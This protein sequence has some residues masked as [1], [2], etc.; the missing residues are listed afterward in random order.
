[1]HNSLFFSV[2]KRKAISPLA[3]PPPAKE[4]KSHLESDAPFFTPSLW[5]KYR[6]PTPHDHAVLSV[7]EDVTEELAE[8]QAKDIP[9][10]TSQA[11]TTVTMPHDETGRTNDVLILSILEKMED[12]KD[13]ARCERDY[14]LETGNQYYA[15]AR[16]VQTYLINNVT[17]L[18][19]FKSRIFAHR[20]KTWGGRA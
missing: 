13:R 20:N 6:L 9:S 7:Y 2:P 5:L 16:W 3:Q 18:I 4:P 1:M 8:K 17:V 12:R 11:R 14:V 10:P 15:G 19:L